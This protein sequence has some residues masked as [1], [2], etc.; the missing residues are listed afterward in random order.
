VIER[1]IIAVAIALNIT[2]A[3]AFMVDW[4]VGTRNRVKAFLRRLDEGSERKRG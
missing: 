4:P 3:L 2:L 1:F